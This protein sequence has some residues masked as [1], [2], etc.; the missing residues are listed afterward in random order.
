MLAVEI[1]RIWRPLSRH[2]IPQILTAGLDVFST[3]PLPSDHP[4]RN[5]KNVLV[6][7]HIASVSPKAI[8]K[9]RES[10]AEIALAAI[11]GDALP[12]VVNGVN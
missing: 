12:N 8:K 11:L 2:W 10:V 5:M 4:V 1:Y 6:S 9:L 3:E 7:S